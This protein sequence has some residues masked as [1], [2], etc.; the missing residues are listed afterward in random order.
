MR[1]RSL[2]AALPLLAT[3]ARAAGWDVLSAGAVEPG[4]AASVRAF[5]AAT[6]QAVSVRY[7]TAPRLRAAIEAGERPALVIGTAPLI[8]EWTAAGRLAGA[9][10]PIGKVGTGV[11]VR[12][13]APAPA[14]TDAAS[15]AAAVTAASAVVFNRAST[16]QAMDRLFERLGLTAIV[17]PK[18]RRFATGA[19]VLESLEH[20]SGAELGFA[21][22]TEI[23]MVAALNDLGPLP[24]PLQTWTHYAAAALPG[25][26]A[27]AL[28]GWLAGEASRG[29]MRGAGIG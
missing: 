11:V 12:R 4:L 1:R 10:V 5:T 18:S 2:L 6:G 13:G 21:A 23:R 3:P 19:E 16:G 8:A 9:A 22:S 27:E 29:L 14:I 7:A 28:L 26:G 24:E 25:G 15:L 20:G 17:T